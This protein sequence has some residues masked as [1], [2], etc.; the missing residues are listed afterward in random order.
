MFLTRQPPNAHSGFPSEPATFL[1]TRK[2]NEEREIDSVLLTKTFARCIDLGTDI[3]NI[4]THLEISIL[5][6]G[7]KQV[8]RHGGDVLL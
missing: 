6:F 2:G 5:D 7:W 1:L 8:D 4:F 3:V